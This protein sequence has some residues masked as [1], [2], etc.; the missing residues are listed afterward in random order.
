M[1]AHEITLT[2]PEELYDLLA[3]RARTS[4]QALDEVIA[5]ALTRQFALAPEPHL[6]QAPNELV[7]P[8]AAG[9]VAA[10]TTSAVTATVSSVVR[11]TVAGRGRSAMIAAAMA[12]VS[13]AGELHEYSVAMREWV[14]CPR[15]EFDDHVVHGTAMTNHGVIEC[16][17]AGRRK[18]CAA[19]ALANFEQN[20]TSAIGERVAGPGAMHRSIN[21]GALQRNRLR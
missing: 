2:L 20:V 10:I 8:T 13:G 19:F 9:T 7:G 5:Q 14:M 4:A 1:S 16:G 18:Q 15:N 6:T 17:F 12:T 3:S 21:E 11:A